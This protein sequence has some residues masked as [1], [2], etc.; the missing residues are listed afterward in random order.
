MISLKT[1]VD[2]RSDL[3]S[4]ELSTQTHLEKY[5]SFIIM[6]RVSIKIMFC[7]ENKNKQGT[8]MVYKGHLP[9][10]VV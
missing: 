7:F 2:L 3:K 4:K 1:E 5:K 8:L 10:S 9:C 6:S